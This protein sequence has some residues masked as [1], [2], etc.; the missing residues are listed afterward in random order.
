[1]VDNSNSN[2]SSSGAVLP[3]RFRQNEKNAS[4]NKNSIY[5]RRFD[6]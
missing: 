2:N 3:E 6:I 4:R 1:V 5:R